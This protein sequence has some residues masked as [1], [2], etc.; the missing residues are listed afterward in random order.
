MGEKKRMVEV[1][2]SRK[3]RRS[4]EMCSMDTVKKADRKPPRSSWA[5]DRG[6]QNHRE[7]GRSAKARRRAGPEVGH[8]F[9]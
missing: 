9:A 3:S 6:A 2:G 4:E 7:T 5:Q 8:R 1:G